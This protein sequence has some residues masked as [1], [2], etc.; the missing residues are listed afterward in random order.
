[1]IFLNRLIKIVIQP[2]IKFIRLHKFFNAFI[3][4]IVFS[5]ELEAIGNV[6]SFV[7]KNQDGFR[8]FQVEPLRIDK[9]KLIDGPTPNTI[10]TSCSSKTK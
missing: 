4:C 8:R 3:S 10:Y 9:I 1:M 5:D 2:F 6:I 7:K